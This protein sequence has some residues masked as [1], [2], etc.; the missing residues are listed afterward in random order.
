[1]SEQELSLTTSVAKNASPET[2][3][4]VC[5]KA[6]STHLE[7]CTPLPAKTGTVM[8]LIAL[9]RQRHLSQS[10]DELH[11]VFSFF[12]FLLL[13]FVLNNNAKSGS[14]FQQYRKT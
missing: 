4:P 10:A 3:A 1:M 11:S 7:G 6:K 12:F 2:A 8:N 14:E 9:T 13:T 5:F